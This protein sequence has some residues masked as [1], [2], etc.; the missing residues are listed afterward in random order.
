[1]ALDDFED[2]NSKL[3]T[4]RNIVNNRNTIADNLF[5]YHPIEKI[6]DLSITPKEYKEF[7]DYVKTHNMKYIVKDNQELADIVEYFRRKSVGPQ[8]N[9]NWIDTSNVTNMAYL[10]ADCEFNGNISEWDTSNVIT[11]A[12]MF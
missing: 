11:M 5:F 1:L 7:E 8:C 2:D 3:T 9:L 6:K 12:N 10:F 4:K